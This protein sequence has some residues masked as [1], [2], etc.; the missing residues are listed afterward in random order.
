MRNK[1]IL[2]VAGDPYSVFIE[3]FLKSIKRNKYKSPLI[4]I[5]NKENFIFQLKK[6]RINKKIRVLDY[7]NLNKTIINNNKI[8]IIDVELSNLNN[9]KVTLY[10]LKNV[11]K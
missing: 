2:I 10:S 9:K 5:C 6:F 8:N 11:F 4:L 7:K 3:I 1:P